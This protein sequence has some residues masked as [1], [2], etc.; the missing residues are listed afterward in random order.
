MLNTE[1]QKSLH[2]TLA[3]RLSGA[4][5]SDYSEL[6]LGQPWVKLINRTVMNAAGKIVAIFPAAMLT[7]LREREKKHAR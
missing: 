7:T 6:K 2:K 1:H 3:H 5:A 4:S